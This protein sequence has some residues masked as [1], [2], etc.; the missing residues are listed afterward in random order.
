[1]LDT[2]HCV[3]KCTETKKNLYRAK[4][5]KRIN[6]DGR[7]VSV[8]LKLLR[9]QDKLKNRIQHKRQW[10][11]KFSKIYEPPQN[12][13]RQK[14]DTNLV[15]CWG[16][17]N[18]TRHRTNFRCHGNMAPRICEPLLEV[19]ELYTFQQRGSHN[20]EQQRMLGRSAPPAITKQ[21]VSKMERNFLA[22]RP[23]ISFSK[24]LLHGV[25]HCVHFGFLLADQNPCALKKCSKRELYWFHR[26]PEEHC[27]M[28]Q[29][30]LTSAV[31]NV[32]DRSS[33]KVTLT[34]ADATCR[35]MNN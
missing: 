23:I 21:W 12:S 22:S 27:L 24:T 32:S 8:K 9:K 29:Q 30:V 2:I 14:S 10:V 28:L 33:V 13:R 6:N 16:S 5:T 18:I 7:A 35:M 26:S 11:N 1:M 17:Q 31:I 3:S 19:H 34:T 25:A 20:T 4:E 15:P